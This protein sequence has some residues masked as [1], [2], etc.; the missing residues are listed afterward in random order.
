LLE[1]PHE[2]AGLEALHVHGE[3]KQFK[4]RQPL[5]LSKLPKQNLLQKVEG[6]IGIV[7]KIQGV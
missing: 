4:I 1:C 2:N 3:P 5:A 6:L 7:A